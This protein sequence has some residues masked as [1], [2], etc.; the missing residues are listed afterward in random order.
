VAKLRRREFRH[1]T[2]CCVTLDSITR[3][4]AQ[5]QTLPSVRGGETPFPMWH[6]T[7][8]DL[9][10]YSDLFSSPLVF[11]HFLE[12]RQ[13]AAMYPRLSMHD[14][15]EHLSLY[16]AHNRYVDLAKSLQPA[17]EVSPIGFVSQIDKYYHS[18]NAGAA[19]PSKPGQKLAS[20]LRD[21]LALL[22]RKGLEGRSKAASYLLDMSGETRDAFSKAVDETIKR[23]RTKNRLIPFSLFGEAPITVFC[24]IQGF[25]VP[26][27]QW[28]KEY[29]LAYLLRSREP[30]RLS[31]SLF[32]DGTDK[33][34]DVTYDFLS[35]TDMPEDR[36]TE[37]EMKSKQQAQ[38]HIQAFLE[39]TGRKKIERNERCPCGSGRKYKK[40]C[41]RS[42]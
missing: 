22:E 34:T 4:A 8:D 39:R 42:L 27:D 9:R 26:P 14:E 21:V 24:C 5:H 36:I 37:I 16:F 38:S 1:I 13:R 17:S 23:Q 3:L 31:I 2:S 19:S 15:L 29:V 40:C 41:G 6:I 33:L 10:I 12:E 35:L 30:E 20:I 32:F 18:L 11:L 28:R 7:V 25:P